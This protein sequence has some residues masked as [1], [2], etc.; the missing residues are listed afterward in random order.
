MAPVELVQLDPAETLEQ[1]DR[2]EFVVDADLSHLVLSLALGAH[3]LE[4]NGHVPALV[5]RVQ[6][7]RVKTTHFR[8]RSSE[9][10]I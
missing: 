7:N 8:P 4:H 5:G 9:A 6:L 10:S 2:V 1:H 3:V